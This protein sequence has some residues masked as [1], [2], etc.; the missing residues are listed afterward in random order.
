MALFAYSRGHHDVGSLRF[1]DVSLGMV[2]VPLWIPQIADGAGDRRCWSWR[3]W[4][5]WCGWLRGLEPTYRA[6]EEAEGRPAS[7]EEMGE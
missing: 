4:N 5:S 3:C 7:G 2:P 1:N 6:G